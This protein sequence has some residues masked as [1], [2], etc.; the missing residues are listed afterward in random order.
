MCLQDVDVVPTDIAVGLLLV[1][2]YQKVQGVKYTYSRLPQTNTNQSNSLNEVVP[3]LVEVS[4]C[5]G[6][7]APS[8]DFSNKP[9]KVKDW[10][11]V[12]NACHYMEFALGTYTWP[13]YVYMDLFCGVCRLCKHCQY[14]QLYY[15]CH[16]YCIIECQ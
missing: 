6:E 10:M 4:S 3:T 2:Q 11:T 1:H 9:L 7:T 16:L 13:V 15:K 12:D 5:G 8:V 14:V